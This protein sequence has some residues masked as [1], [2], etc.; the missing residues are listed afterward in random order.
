MF[1]NDNKLYKINISKKVKTF[2]NDESSHLNG[3]AGILGKPFKRLHS[4]FRK[5]LTILIFFFF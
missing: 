2:I 4:L 5:V 3:S 1:F